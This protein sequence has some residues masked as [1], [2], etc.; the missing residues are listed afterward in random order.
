MI[1]AWALG[2]RETIFSGYRE[3]E[4]HR[5]FWRVARESRN[6]AKSLLV[7]KWLSS[8]LAGDAEL[9]FE[10]FLEAGRRSFPASH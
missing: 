2:E 1:G 7:L 5:D 8:H 10:I 9:A 6:G 4:L 3:V